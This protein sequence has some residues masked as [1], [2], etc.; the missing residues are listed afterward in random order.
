[1]EKNKVSFCSIVSA[2]LLGKLSCKTK[3]FLESFDDATSMP[4]GYLLVDFK[5]TTPDNMRLRTAILSD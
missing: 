3:Y 5:A 2:Y 4:Y 1:M